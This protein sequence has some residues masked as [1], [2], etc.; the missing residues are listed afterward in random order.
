[1]CISGFGSFLGDLK[2]QKLRTL[3]AIAFCARPLAI[4]MATSNGEVTL[5]TPSLTEPSGKVIL[6]GFFGRAVEYLG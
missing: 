6:I 5:D 3:A 2:N 1:M 4:A